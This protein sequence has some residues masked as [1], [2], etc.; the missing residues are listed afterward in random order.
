MSK[1]DKVSMTKYALM[2]VDSMNIG[3]A[4]QAIAARQ[5]LPRVDFLVER[6]DFGKMSELDLPKNSKLKMIMNGWY[7]DDG[8]VFPPPRIDGF[9]PLLISMHVNDIYANNYTA[10]AFLTDES[11]KFFQDFAPLGARDTHTEKFLTDNGVDAYFSGCLT[12]TLT[13]ENSLTQ[14]DHILAVNVSDAVYEALCQRTKRPVIRMD[15]DATQN[16]SNEEMLAMGEYYLVLYQTA[17]LVVTTRLH[18]T[19]PTLA[20]GGNVLF[21]EETNAVNKDFKTRFSGLHTL[22]NHLSATEFIND[23]QSEK[24]DLE[25]PVKSDLGHNELR[26]NLIKRSEEYIG[27]KMTKGFLYGKTFEQL[28]TSKEFISAI[29]KIAGESSL[30]Y[31]AEHG[32]NVDR[33]GIKPLLRSLIKKMLKKKTW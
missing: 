11:K 15:V 14:Q 27:Q 5:F 3:D 23:K 24:Y 28:T 25:R 18:A 1:T 29:T 2:V 4:V 7:I 19:L 8:A 33:I 6:D 16:L 32:W 31:K 22:V 17:H 12:L 10:K 26:N 20:M 21:I 9:E 30:F 13:R